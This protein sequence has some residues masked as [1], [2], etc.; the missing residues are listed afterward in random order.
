MV[1]S[2]SFLINSSVCGE[3][4][5][6]EENRNRNDAEYG[7]RALFLDLARHVASEGSYSSLDFTKIYSVG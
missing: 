7:C 5:L 2:V 3:K 1:A 4:G 6:L